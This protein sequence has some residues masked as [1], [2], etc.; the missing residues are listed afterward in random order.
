VV[1]GAYPVAP[2]R[3]GLVVEPMQCASGPRGLKTA[4]P[5]KA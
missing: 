3:R 4:H 2:T 5:L 1:V